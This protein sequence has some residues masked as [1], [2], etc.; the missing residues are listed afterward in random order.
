MEF[1]KLMPKEISYDVTKELFD[2]IANAFESIKRDENHDHAWNRPVEKL[3]GITLKLLNDE[4]LLLTYHFY[5]VGSQQDARRKEDEGKIFLKNTVKELKKRFKK[6]TGKA[7]KMKKIQEDASIEAVNRL[8][9]VNMN[10]TKYLFRLQYVYA[11]SA[12]LE[13]YGDDD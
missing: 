2:S 8:N 11:F 6:I 12:S 13:S 7:L 5:E 9:Y 4:Q 1:I 10:T 3:N